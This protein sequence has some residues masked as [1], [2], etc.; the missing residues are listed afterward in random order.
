MKLPTQIPIMIKY[1]DNPELQAEH[2]TLCKDCVFIEPYF[3]GNKYY[4]KQWGD[5]QTCE[6][7]YCFKGKSK[8]KDV[9][10]KLP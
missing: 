8:A 5:L 4:C 6:Y 1:G 2:I 7:G 3:S 10:E 9:Q